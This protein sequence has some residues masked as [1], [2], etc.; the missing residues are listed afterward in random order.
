MKKPYGLWP[1]PLTTKALAGTLRL[2]E[3]AWAGDDQQTLVWLEGRSGQNILVAQTGTDAPHD[4]ISDHSAKGGVGY[5]GGEFGVHG[6]TVYFGNKDGRLFKVALQ[7]GKPKAI[8]P[9]HGSVASPTPSPDGQWVAYVHTD[10]HTDVIA[11][12]D[13]DGKSWPQKFVSGA[14]FYMQPTWS[15]DGKKFAWVA[16]DHPQMPWDGARI[17]VA[18][19]HKTEDGRLALKATNV[20]AGNENTS[21]QQPVFSPNGTKLAYTS[22]A[23]GFIQ[24][25]VL[26]L[27]TG[28]DRVISDS[29]ADHATPAWIQGRRTIAWTPDG[30]RVLALR[31]EA[32][33]ASLRSYALG[34]QMQHFEHVSQYGM[35]EQLS[36]NPAGQV[37]LIVSDSTIPARIVRIDDLG[38]KNSVRI[39]KRAS[40][41]RLPQEAL[42]SMQPVSWQANDGTQVFGNYYAPTNPNVEGIGL[43]PL[44]VMIHGGPT[45]QS[46]ATYNARSQFFATRGFAVLEVNYRGST[47]Y[48]R[49]YMDAL[50]GQWGILDVEDAIGGAQH[51]VDEGLVDKDKLVIM[52][53]SAGGYTVFQALTDHPGFFA[54]GIS[55]YGITN[56]F[57]L[58]ASTHKFESRY[59]DSLLGVLPEDAQ[60]FKDRSPFFKSDKLRDPIAIFQGA[61]DV[62][63]PKEQADVMVEKLRAQ[64]VPHV[65]HVYENEGHGWRSAET[66]EHFYKAVLDFLTNTIIYA[67]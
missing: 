7:H 60:L 4:L 67:A 9:K 30:Q 40:S 15:P 37:A 10:H 45:S 39:C 65:Y 28:D 50:K 62:V 36:V 57:S 52:G 46:T 8:T 61:K 55:M 27:I 16:W 48:G 63:V 51:L 18:E 21:V 17:E 23:S 19:V 47:G 29:G 41:E 64:K 3:V 12:V 42:A 14:D 59:N 35:L 20:I 43:P 2:M 11:L 24:I 66:I 56:L 13:T 1:S 49:K 58:T 34:G 44:L 26:D 32:G 6:Q 31:F 53:G 5:G 38:D 25:H 22:D 33:R 54:A